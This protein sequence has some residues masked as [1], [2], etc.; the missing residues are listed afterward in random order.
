MSSSST[1]QFPAHLGRVRVWDRAEGRSVELHR[2]DWEQA[3]SAGLGTVQVSSSDDTWHWYTPVRSLDFRFFGEPLGATRDVRR[4]YA[5]RTAADRREFWR[6]VHSLTTTRLLGDLADHE[7]RLRE[8]G[9]SAVQDTHLWRVARNELARRRGRSYRRAGRAM[10]PV[11]PPS[12]AVR[13]S[14]QREI[15][16]QRAAARGREEYRAWAR[17]DLEAHA[18]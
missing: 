3:L 7:D 6:Q 18:E 10:S 14:D 17:A 8:E 16:R 11:N 15:A 13:A 4:Q 9:V 5:R 2:V 12:D 1:Y